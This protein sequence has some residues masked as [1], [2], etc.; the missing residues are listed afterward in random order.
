MWF[1]RQNDGRVRGSVPA[2]GARRTRAARVPGRWLR[3]L[4]VLVAAGGLGF[5]LWRAAARLLWENPRYTLRSLTIDV[6][7][8]MISPQHVREYTGLREGMN[9]FAF[10]L[11][12]VRAE[13]LKKAPMVRAVSI[14]RR[15]PDALVIHVSER[16]TV[17]KIGRWPA[18]LGVDP[19]GW[20]F[21]LRVGSRRLPAITGP[22]TEALRPGMRVGQPVLNAL[23]FLKVCQESKFAR[24]LD[25]ASIDVSRKEWL[26]VFLAQGE[27]IRIAWDG[28]GTG[29]TAARQALERKVGQLAGALQASAERGHRLA[30]LD[31][32][33]HERYVP[34]QEF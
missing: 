21:P 25:I 23:E 24:E 7:G 2:G 5:V 3:I 12:K 22:P 14:T 6:E 27:R 28:M 34:A 15:L 29:T 9:I 13:F 19:E 10:N 18:V 31:L 20:V 33:F 30:N 1:G 8:Q 4:V 16:V 17:A 11:R 32:T 26:E